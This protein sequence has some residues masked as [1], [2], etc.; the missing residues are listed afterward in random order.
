MSLTTALATIVGKAIATKLI[1]RLG[2]KPNGVEKMAA[3]A[4]AV[5]QGKNIVEAFHGVFGDDFQKELNAVMGSGKSSFSYEAGTAEYIKVDPDPTRSPLAILRD[6][7][8]INLDRLRYIE[9]NDKEGLKSHFRGMFHVWRQ[10]YQA[11]A[12]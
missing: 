3:V 11:L 9:T 6:E 8:N 5:E 4:T 12:A 1:K 2:N 10:R 7:L